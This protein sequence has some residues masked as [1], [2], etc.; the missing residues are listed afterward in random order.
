MCC[1]SNAPSLPPVLAPSRMAP[2]NSNIEA[3][4]TACQYLSA[5]ADTEVPKALACAGQGKGGQG[6]QGSGREWRAGVLLLAAP[7]AAGAGLS[8]RVQWQG[9][10]LHADCCMGKFRTPVRLLA[11]L[12]AGTRAGGLTHQVIGADAVAFG[13]ANDGRYSED[14]CVCRVVYSI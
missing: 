9:L 14:P 2:R 13:K 5:L 10:L 1:P 12:P 11:L 4:T 6:S 8:W 3:T 7:G